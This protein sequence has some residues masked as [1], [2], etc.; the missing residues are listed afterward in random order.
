MNDKIIPVYNLIIHIMNDK[1]I[2]YTLSGLECTV[3]IKC[4]RMLLSH[5][6]NFL[7]HC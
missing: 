6:A 3:G 2:R 7:F 5:L 4:V 1:I